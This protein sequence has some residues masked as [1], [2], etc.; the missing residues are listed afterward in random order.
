MT[1][2]SGISSNAP[3]CCPYQ[4][5]HPHRVEPP[6]V[7]SRVA[8]T[9]LR[10][11]SVWLRCLVGRSGRRAAHDSPNNRRVRP[12]EAAWRGEFRRREVRSGD[13]NRRRVELARSCRRLAV[14]SLAGLAHPCPARGACASRDRSRQLNTHNTEFREVCYRWHPWF[15]RTVVVYE[16]LVKL[17]QSVCR[18]GLEEERN[19]LSIE[20]PAWMFDS[21]ACSCLRV[22]TASAVS[23][24]ALRALQ[25]LVRAMSPPA[26]LAAH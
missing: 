10:T 2:G 16:V 3:G 5:L 12:S 20:I 19:R 9:R 8:S 21:G 11:K 24:D 6:I 25:A 4:K 1:I 15:G 7:C 23:T 17:G 26:L 13:V 14:G 18:C 22:M